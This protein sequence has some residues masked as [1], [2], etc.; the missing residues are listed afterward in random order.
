MSPSRLHHHAIPLENVLQF[1][2]VVGNKTVRRIEFIASSM[3]PAPA[4]APAPAPCN[5]TVQYLSFIASTSGSRA[6]AIRIIY[7]IKII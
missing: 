7:A 1:I 3:S 4:P 5:V 6:D 2:V